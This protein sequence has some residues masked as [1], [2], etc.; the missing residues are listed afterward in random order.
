MPLGSYRCWVFLGEPLRRK[1]GRM[2]EA[3]FWVAGSREW[4]LDEFCYYLF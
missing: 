2:R 3:S 1:E 4:L